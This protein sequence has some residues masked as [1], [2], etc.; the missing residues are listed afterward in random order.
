MTMQ[1]TKFK[2]QGADVEIYGYE[3]E[4]IF[5]TI[6]SAK[7]F[8]EIDL[9]ELL[10]E[11]FSCPEGSV[12]DVGANIGNHTVY[13]GKICSRKVVAFE[14]VLQNI[15]VLKK[16]VQANDIED[17]VTIHARGC[18]SSGRQLFFKQ[19]IENNGGTFTVG[20]EGEEAGVVA[21][22]DAI[23]ENEEIAL[24]KID[25]EGSEIEVLRG[26]EKL[27]S[28]CRPVLSIELQSSPQ[29]AEVVRF[30][31][32]QEYGVYAIRGRSDNY[33]C[34]PLDSL[35]PRV[36]IHG[37]KVE[38]EDRR[39]NKRD[40]SRI[41]GLLTT[42]SSR[43]E[44]LKEIDGHSLKN[45]IELMH[46]FDSSIKQIVAMSGRTDRALQGLD[47]LGLE[48][49]RTQILLG[50][51]RLDL[52]QAR[53][54]L[55]DGLLEVARD[56][57]SGVQTVLNQL[58]SQDMYGPFS[59]LEMQN[60]ELH[61]GIKDLE[62][63][64]IKCEASTARNAFS[65][66]EVSAQ[67]DRISAAVLGLGRESQSI[68]EQLEQLMELERE[69]RSSRSGGTHRPV[70]G[71]V[72]S[73]CA[74]P[75]YG[76]VAEDGEFA[77]VGTAIGLVSAKLD[78]LASRLTK[79]QV[80]GRPKGLHHS[81]EGSYPE[82][83]IALGEVAV[84]LKD[85]RAAVQR[86]IDA[87]LLSKDSSDLH[88]DQNISEYTSILEKCLRELKDS[89]D[90]ALAPVGVGGSSSSDSA[91]IEDDLKKAL[92]AYVNLSNR[93][94]LKNPDDWGTL[95]SLKGLKRAFKSDGAGELVDEALG[96]ISE[97]D[98]NAASPPVSASGSAVSGEPGST[99]YRLPMEAR[100]RR[101]DRVRV[102][103]ASMPGRE[104]GLATVVSILH[105]QADEIFVY[106]NGMEEIPPALPSFPNVRYVFGPDLGDR[107]KFAFLEGFNGYYLTCDDDIAYAPFHVDSLIDGIERY[108]RE[109]VVGWHGSIFKPGFEKF[110]DAQSRQ[111]LSF[112]FLRGRDTPVHLLGTGVCGFHTDTLRISLDDF[113]YPNMADAFVAVAAKEQG[114]PMV[115]LKH[116][117]D[118][119]T[120]IEV[121]PSISTVSLGRDVD[122]NGGLDVAATV[123]DIVKKNQPWSTLEAEQ[124][125][126]REVFSVGLVGRTSKE[127]WKKGGIL[128]SSHLTV[129]ALKRF[130]VET[131]LEDI[132]VGDPIGFNGAEPSIVLVYVGDP[133]RPDFTEVEKVVAHHA[134]LGRHVVINLSLNG[135]ERRNQ[136][137]VTMIKR[138]RNQFGN[139]I[140]LM[141]FTEAAK[142][143]AQLAPIREA[144]VVIPKTIE[145]PDAPMANFYHSEGIFL[146]DIAK[147][148]DDSLCGIPARE[149]IASIRKVLP[150][151]PLYT[152]KQYKPKVDQKLDVDEIWP[153]LTKGQF[154]EQISRTRLMISLVKYATFEMVPLEVSALGIPVLYPDM[155]Q[156]LSEYLGLSGVSISTP[157]DLELILPSI[158][159]DPLVWRSLSQSGVERA[160]SSELNRTSGQTYL[161]LLR[162]IRENA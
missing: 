62:D 75:G 56:I 92:N 154:G 40:L 37:S 59:Y 88:L 157:E 101:S 25:V 143:L 150:G 138:W 45:V 120:P 24:I 147:L 115:V 153:F 28:R 128:K 19:V 127:R 10:S 87:G 36:S 148:N 16:N 47:T 135:K 15:E 84:L 29:T 91:L 125:Y 20:S 85:Q 81:P 104:A 4:Y 105:Q 133:E 13:F 83:L 69:S 9:L 146:G 97:K 38:V 94:E 126:H 103:I 42:V 54:T 90:E 98:G 100:G 121:G 43:T 6:K 130:G 80:T 3:G 14:P 119:A 30:L 151:V 137:I 162:L 44:A 152:V 79:D 57:K 46:Q 70:P 95:H 110:Y 141:V 76:A 102:G 134:R 160:T 118:D 116:G 113:I 11:S 18:W 49:K 60:Q 23:D 67:L 123:T 35:D 96:R 86:V 65:L 1:K 26:A 68:H 32:E 99:V 12:I 112:R 31:E 21:L 39:Q 158:Y 106:L 149:W 111:V 77:K 41:I 53:D 145:L 7:N 72:V 73:N 117:K 82:V 139:I 2:H 161:Q 58:D 48:G 107:G 5:K 124:K 66:S 136:L 33:I 51:V 156:S 27:I 78:R 52:R 74:G 71:D 155:P 8:Y 64:L 109:A 50:D 131:F 122:K 22:D 114:V 55:S 89:L 132:E 144:I 34:L 140:R 108:N 61:E 142:N 17:L 129:Q 63:S 159:H 93:Y